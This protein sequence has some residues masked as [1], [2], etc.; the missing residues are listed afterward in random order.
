MASRLD[1]LAAVVSYGP[2]VYI[3]PG[4][5]SLRDLL[6]SLC[7]KRVTVMAEAGGMAMT[8]DATAVRRRGG[9]YLY[10]LGPAQLILRELYE[11][12]KGGAKRRPMPIIIHRITA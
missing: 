3:R 5:S 9:C 10:P 11:R 7:G 12:Y 4:T 1:A 8:F 2:V 6:E